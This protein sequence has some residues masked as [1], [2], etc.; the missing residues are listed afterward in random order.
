MRMR[1]LFLITCA[2]LVSSALAACTHSEGEV[3]QSDRDCDDG[4]VCT[5]DEFERGFCQDPDDVDKTP[6]EVDAGE[7]DLGPD[8]DMDAGNET[9]GASGSA[10]GAGGSAG[11]DAMDAS[12]P[13]DE[14]A[15]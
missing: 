13:P 3:C 1:F 12:S 15:G 2:L 7:P 6:P 8:P 9:G 10:G 5:P 11:S 14:D 4:L